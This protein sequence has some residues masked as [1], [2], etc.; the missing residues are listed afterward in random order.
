MFHPYLSEEDDRRNAGRVMTSDEAEAEARA[1]G[2]CEDQQ[3]QKAISTSLAHI[4]KKEVKHG[5]RFGRK[6]RKGI[7]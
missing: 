3:K 6:A 7:R 2:M 1:A 4:E 5:I